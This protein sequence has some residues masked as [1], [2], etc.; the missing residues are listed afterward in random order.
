MLFPQIFNQLIPLHSSPA[1]PTPPPAPSPKD[2]TLQKLSRSFL[3][4][5]LWPCFLP[6]WTVTLDKLSLGGLG[7]EGLDFL[8]PGQKACK[9]Q[10]EQEQE[11]PFSPCI[12]FVLKMFPCVLRCNSHVGEDR[13]PTFPPTLD[14]AIVTHFENLTVMRVT[15]RE[16][17]NWV[18]GTGWVY[19]S[20][21]AWRRFE[22]IFR[23]LKWLNS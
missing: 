14:V 3:T 23:I 13:K 8:F 17:S 19:L 21:L 20:H 22:N 9:L 16:R 5:T 7:S 4:F 18:H 12:L 15:S 10:R 6:L 11:E 1:P 2:L